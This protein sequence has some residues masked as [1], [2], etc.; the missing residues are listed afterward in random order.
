MGLP[1]PKFLARTSASIQIVSGTD[2]NGAPNVVSEFN[3]NCRSEQ[4][5]AVAFTKEGRDVPLKSKVFIFEKFE[6]FPDEIAGFCTINSVRHD[7]VN[8][9]KKLNPDGSINH[10]VLELI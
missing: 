1:V 9:S 6:S 4:S 2:E 8:G 5:N 7:I 3:V 10:I